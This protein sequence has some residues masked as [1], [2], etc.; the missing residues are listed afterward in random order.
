M[1]L[2]YW[3]LIIPVI[4]SII[5]LFSDS[6]IKKIGKSIYVLTIIILLVL[7]V[8]I[9]IKLSDE[10]NNQ[11]SGRIEGF[12]IEDNISP[13]FKVGGT[14]FLL[15]NNPNLPIFNLSNALINIPGLMDPIYLYIENNELKLSVTIRNERKEIIAK[16]RNN[17]WTLENKE[18]LDKNF[19]KHAIEVVDK[20]NEV[21]LQVKFDGNDVEFAG[22]FYLNDY[23]NAKK[24]MIAP[25]KE[26][27]AVLIFAPVEQD[28]DQKIERIFKYPSK[29]HLG[30]R[31]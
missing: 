25:S 14:K 5:A 4:L 2:F 10:I 26:G 23:G 8:F 15:S 13:I 12:V 30:E 29:R 7:Q 18:I 11:Y 9:E 16:I 24:L 19:D 21:I 20:N 28:F 31:V 1:E 17:T 3:K 27:G 22:I 6:T